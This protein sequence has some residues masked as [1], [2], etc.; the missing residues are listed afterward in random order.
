MYLKYGSYTHADAEVSFT[1]DSQ[2]LE[3]EA[4]QQ[5]GYRNTWR[6]EGCLQ[7]DDTTAVVTAFR[8][9]ETAYSVWYRDLVFYDDSGNITHKLLN[10]GSL[11]GVKIVSPPSYPRGEGAELSTF[12]HYTLMASADYPAGAG[13]NALRSFSETLAFTGGGPE[14]TVVECANV[15]PQEQVLKAFTMFRAVQSGS[16]VGMFQYPVIPPPL[17]PGKERIRS[18]PP[19]NPVHGSPKLRNGRY[20]DWPVSW[21]YEFISATPLV[22]FPNRWPAG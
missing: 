20:I 10:A 22:G 2:S 18:V 7:A 15:P 19:G 16:A 12:R 6:I 21:S 11:T 5:Y 4:G 3:N 9:L 13:L 8:A 17:F 1:I 14:R